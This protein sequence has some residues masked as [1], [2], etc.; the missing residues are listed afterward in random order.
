MKRHLWRLGSPP[1]DIVMRIA[2][3]AREYVAIRLIRLQ[4][5]IG[6]LQLPVAYVADRHMILGACGACAHKLRHLRRSGSSP[7]ST[8]VPTDRA[9]TNY[10]A[11]RLIRLP[12]CIAWLRAPEA[13]LA[14]RQIFR[15]TCGASAACVQALATVRFI[16][17][18]ERHSQ[19]GRSTEP[20]E[21][22]QS[23]RLMCPGTCSAW[24]LTC[25]GYL[26]VV[27]DRLMRY[28]ALGAWRA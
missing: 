5:C 1:D 19:H 27:S 18:S 2:K 3:C 4:E 11:V 10:V 8:V 14:I 25:Y 28:S 13:H 12:E 17:L 26:A 16:I 21:A 23:V 24:A 22:V 6:L 15:G 20:A 7:D 9:D